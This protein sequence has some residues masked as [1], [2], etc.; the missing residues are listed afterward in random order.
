ML[1]TYFFFCF[2]GTAARTTLQA[3]NP[4][5][6]GNNPFPTTDQD[7]EPYYEDLDK[8]DC[9]GKGG[10]PLPSSYKKMASVKVVP[11]VST[12]PEYDYAAV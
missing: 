8:Y 11:A 9:T 7:S 10:D 5:P 1:S 2:S 12:V 3:V 4:L 6:P